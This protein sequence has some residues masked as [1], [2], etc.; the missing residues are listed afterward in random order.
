MF[1]AA[2]SRT[3]SLR[4]V[5]AIRQRNAVQSRQMKFRDEADKIDGRC[6][7]LA[8]SVACRLGWLVVAGGRVAGGSGKNAPLAEVGA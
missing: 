7:R 6:G 1:S 5:R 3:M 8:A 2:R 4:A